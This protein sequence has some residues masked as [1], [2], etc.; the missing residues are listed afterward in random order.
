[1]PSLKKGTT[2]CRPKSLQSK[3]KS[4][5]DFKTLSHQILEYANRGERRTDFHREISKMLLDFSGAD[6]IEFWLTGHGKYF[7]SETNTLVRE[8]PHFEMKSYAQNEKGEIIPGPD[9]SQERVDLYNIIIQGLLDFPQPLVTEKGSLWIGNSKKPFSLRLTLGESSWIRTYHL[10][11][12]YSSFLL[13][14]LHMNRNKMGLLVFKS[15]Q[16]HFIK[17]GEVSLYEDLS[18]DLAIAVAHRD[19]QVDLRERIK[20][21]TCL[22]GIAS[23][24]AQPNLPVG[25]ILKGIV[26][27]LPPALLYSEIASAEIILDGHSYATPGFLE[28][29]HQLMA[30]IVINRE[31]RGVVKVAYSEERPELD[32]GP[33]LEEERNLVETVAK[34]VGVIILRKQAEQ[35]KFDLQEQLRHAE[36]LATIGQ[37]AAGVAHELNEP[38]G[39]ILGFAQL[40]I[41][42][43]GLPKQAESDIEKILAASLNAREVVKKLLIFARKLPPKKTKVNINQLIEDGLLFFKTRFAKE[44][45][46]LVR[47]LSPDLPEIDADPAQLN[48]VVVN[49]TTNA[50]QAMKTGGRLTISTLAGKEY[51]TLIVEDTGVGMDEEVMKQIFTPFF[52]TKE[53]GQGTGLGL[54]VVHGIVT[55]HGGSI[56]VFSKPNQGSRFEIQLPITQGQEGE[57]TPS[58]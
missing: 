27:L 43:P 41:K 1:M 19:I 17:K 35:E 21:L 54:P 18:R 24:A 6:A 8:I 47:S 9:E 14:P 11:D 33:F 28:A 39:N 46:E 38:L 12:H 49:L 25:E 50:L 23:L 42:C 56:K 52:T 3:L 31:R 26:D 34:E 44:N 48:Q 30:D 16:S 37:L 36:R 15:K 10:R 32:E 57:W 5:K 53:V 13:T 2:I 29:K 45:I 22:Y 51:I 4:K 58:L 55:A 40:A 20:E 7:R